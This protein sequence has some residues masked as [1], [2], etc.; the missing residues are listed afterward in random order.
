M[1]DQSEADGMNEVM[2][3]I[4]HGQKIQAVKRYME[5]KGLELDEMP[6]LLESKKFIEKL[7]AQLR[8][9]YPERFTQA[10]SSGC[11]GAMFMLVAFLGVGLWCFKNWL[12]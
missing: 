7:T 4:Y 2:E 9:K 3:F 12:A 8:E 10:K 11:A 5:L 1:E 6:S